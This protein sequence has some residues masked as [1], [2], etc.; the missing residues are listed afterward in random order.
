MNYTGFAVVLFSGIA[1]VAL[2][3]LRRR[4]PGEARPY[5]AWGYPV[6]P[7]IFVIVSA[8]I[9]VNAVWR[10]PGPSG[11]GVGIILAGLPLYWYLQR[12]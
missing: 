2:F 6:A 7:G 12:R 3:V 10:N 4:N 5:R 11:A 9:V 8:V 1:G